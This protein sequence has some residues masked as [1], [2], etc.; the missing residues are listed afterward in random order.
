MT[1]VSYDHDFIYLRTRKTAGTSTEMYL[2]PFCISEGMIVTERNPRQ[3]ISKSGIVGRRMTSET[4]SAFGRARLFVRDQLGLINWL[5]HM[6]ASK[7]RSAL[8]PVFWDRATK[9]SSVR[10]P[11]SRLVSSFYWSRSVRNMKTDSSKKDIRQFRRK[12]RNGVFH[13]D[14]D[15][16]MIGNTFVPDVL[17]RQEHLAEDLNALAERLGLDTSRTGLPETKKTKSSDTAV[18]PPL[19]AFY[20]DE[21]ADIVR[22]RFAWAFEHGKYSLEVPA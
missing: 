6:P 9:I 21:T 2:Q 7:V 14:Q 22:E 5:A 12:I 1:L 17:I 11:F 8:D 10:N 19:R 20:D 4:P 15:I 3:I 18:R 16:V 13:D